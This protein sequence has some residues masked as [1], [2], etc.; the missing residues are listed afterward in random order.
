[1]ERSGAGSVLVTSGFGY[2]SG[3]PKNIWIQIRMR[4]RIPNTAKDHSS[5]LRF[6]AFTALQLTSE[7]S[8][9]AGTLCAGSKPVRFR[10]T[11]GARSKLAKPLSL[12]R[13]CT[14]SKP[15]KPLSLRGHCAPGKKQRNLYHC[16]DTVHP[17]VNQ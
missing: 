4:I 1:M 16:G 6:G 10:C 13:H 12:R 14:G 17:E 3:R 8:T 2:G 15:V 7:T 11:A 5:L 9:S